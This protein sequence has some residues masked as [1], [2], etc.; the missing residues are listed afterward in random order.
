[1]ADVD[2]YLA[3]CSPPFFSSE[4]VLEQL[5]DHQTLNN[6]LVESDLIAGPNCNVKPK[7]RTNSNNATHYT[8]RNASVASVMGVNLLYMPIIRGKKG[9]CYDVNQVDDSKL[10]NRL[11]KNRESADQSRKRKLE[12]A[13]QYE[14]RLAELNA[15]NKRLMEVNKA[16][17]KH[18]SE[19]ELALSQLRDDVQAPS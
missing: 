6:L 13:R 19:I 17:L 15:E 2:G 9:L 8:K 18:I 4:L 7:I 1:M 12:K 11:I 10:R 16:L 5:D 3:I 14:T